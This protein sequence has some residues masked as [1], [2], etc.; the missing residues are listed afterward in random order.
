M[1]GQANFLCVL[2]EAICSR[3]QLSEEN[4]VEAWVAWSFNHL[5]GQSPTE[6]RLTEWESKELS[7]NK[8]YTPKVNDK[9]KVYS[10]TKIEY[11]FFSLK[12]YYLPLFC[13]YC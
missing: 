10:S 7:K 2:G 12:H 11:P 9:I 1:I 8:M 13:I 6:E 5:D 3:Y 4:F